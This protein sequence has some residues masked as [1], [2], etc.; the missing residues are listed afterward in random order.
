VFLNL[1][2]NSCNFT[3]A[4]HALN[5]NAFF[6]TKNLFPEFQ[7]QERERM[8]APNMYYTYTYNDF[9]AVVPPIRGPGGK[10]LKFY[11]M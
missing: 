10:N 2:L 4:A 3:G 9:S 8:S 1:T 11:W 7:I 5:L 6:H